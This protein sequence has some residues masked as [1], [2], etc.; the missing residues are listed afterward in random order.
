M[1][2]VYIKPA[3]LSRDTHHWLDLADRETFRSSQ[4]LSSATSSLGSGTN[5]R[6][7]RSLPTSG[8]RL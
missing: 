8:S 5:F 2:R 4:R 3:V 6:M 1:T 7:V